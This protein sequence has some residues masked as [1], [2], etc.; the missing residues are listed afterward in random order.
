[1]PNQERQAHAISDRHS[2]LLKSAK[3]IK[4]IGEEQFG[5]AHDILEVGCGSGIIS[6]ALA[7][8]GGD[9]VKVCAVDVADNRVEKK[10]YTF[11]QVDGTTLPYP[12]KIF[13]IVVSN[14]VIE[15]VGDRKAQLCHLQEIR[16]VLKV[17]GL[18][19]LAVPN[20]WRVVEPHYRLPLLSWFPQRICDAYLRLFKRGRYYDCAPLSARH[21]M[22]LFQDAHLL[23]DNATLRALRVTLQ[24]EHSA[25]PVT[26]LV[27][28]LLPDWSLAAFLPIIPTFVFLLRPQ[29]P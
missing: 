8:A 28:G 23:A 29:Q 21:A 17:N 4:L 19:Y 3:I 18:I 6:N 22:A 12:D 2:R 7:T 13:D 26:R 20:K 27:N 10:G 24:A 25:H 5:R 16:R 15:H 1:M 9:R 14:H 11:Q